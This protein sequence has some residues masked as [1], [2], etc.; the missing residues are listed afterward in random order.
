M[1]Q[2]TLYSGEDGKFLARIVDRGTRAFVLDMGVPQVIGDAAQRVQHGFTMWQHG[3][4]ISAHPEDPNL[5]SQLAAYYAAEGLLVFYEEPDW[6]GRAP[7]EVSPEFSAVSFIPARR[8]EL[9]EDGDTELLSL[10]DLPQLESLLAAISPAPSL[11]ELLDAPDR[12]IG[13]EDLLTEERPWLE[14]RMRERAASQLAEVGTRDLPT[15]VLGDELGLGDLPTE[16][17]TDLDD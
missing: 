15:E 2:L 13:D 14:E 11:D 17:L 3:Q 6:S 1:L 12:D 16:I 8:N 9:L 5:L 4:L 7:E 10:A